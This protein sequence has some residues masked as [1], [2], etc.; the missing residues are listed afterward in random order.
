MKNYIPVEGKRNLYRDSS[1]NSIVNT[2]SSE[3]NA[4][5]QMKNQKLKEQN[6]INSLKEEFNNM[7]ND[8]NEIKTLLKTILNNK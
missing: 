8:L 4:Y 7:K 2:D 3:Y 1:S 5:M 6:E